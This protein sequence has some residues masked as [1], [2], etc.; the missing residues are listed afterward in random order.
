M[1]YS[2]DRIS[3]FCFCIANAVAAD[4]RASRL[5]H[6]RQSAGENTLQNF[7][8]AFLRKTHESQRSQWLS[9]HG[10]NVAERVGRGDLAEDV[11]IVYDGRKKIHRLHEGLLGCQ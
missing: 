8:V 7:E 5:D 6:L 4:H 2:R 11:G 10:I 1:N 9:A 3:K